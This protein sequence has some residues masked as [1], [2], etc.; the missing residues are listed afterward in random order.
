MIVWG[1]GDESNSFL[2]FDTGGRYDP[3]TDTWI[4]TS[5]TDA[6]CSRQYHTAVWT[7]GEMIVWGGEVGGLAFASS[8]GR[9]CAQPS[10]PLV[11]SV[12]CR[13]THGTAGSFSVNLPLSG[14]PGIECRSGGVTND[15][16]IVVTFLANVSVNASPQVAVTSGIGAIG[17]GGLAMAAWSRPAKMS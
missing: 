2:F 16:T 6:P 14:T 1:G 5:T 3:T 12:V 8:G 17:S 7:G 4:D 10:T 13:K 11:Q 9:Y 15:Y